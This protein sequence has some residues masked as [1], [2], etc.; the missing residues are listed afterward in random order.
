[1]TR[2][3]RKL[4]KGEGGEVEAVESAVTKDDVRMLCCLQ[5]KQ[6]SYVKISANGDLSILGAQEQ[7]EGEYMCIATNPAGSDSVIVD[8]E[9]GGQ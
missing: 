4:S 5:L 9:V 1:M 8:L 2:K 6:L 3:L 7:D